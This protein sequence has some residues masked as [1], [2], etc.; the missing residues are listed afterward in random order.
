MSSLHTAFVLSFLVVDWDSNGSC[1]F[2]TKDADSGW[3][4]GRLGGRMGGG[5]WGGL[6]WVVEGDGIA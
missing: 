4:I 1:N 3:Y 6:G 5:L 2:G